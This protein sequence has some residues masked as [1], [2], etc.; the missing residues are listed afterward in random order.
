MKQYFAYHSE[1]VMGYPATLLGNP[2]YKTS[3]DA[4]R[5]KGAI[6]WLISSEGNSPMS[7]YVA[8]KFVGKFIMTGTVKRAMKTTRKLNDRIITLMWSVCVIS[9]LDCRL[10]ER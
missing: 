8:A 2:C 10:Y 1:S 7:F 5:Y 3:K 6:I 4:G 9:R